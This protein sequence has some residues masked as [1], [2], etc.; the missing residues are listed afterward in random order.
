M[1]GMTS[2]L[3]KAVSGFNALGI[4]YKKFSN[5][6]VEAAYGGCTTDVKKFCGQIQGI[7]QD[8]VK[9]LNE[10][11]QSFSDLDENLSMALN[12]NEPSTSFK[13]PTHL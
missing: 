6:A 11:A 3:N 7:L 9:S 2:G 1:T 10:M 8:D 12:G 5:C 13:F 4:A